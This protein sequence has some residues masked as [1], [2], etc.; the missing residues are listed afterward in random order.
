MKKHS[1]TV[2]VLLVATLMGLFFVS[3]WQGCDLGTVSG[4]STEH[5]SSSQ[6][7]ASLQLTNQRLRN[8]GTMTFHLYPAFSSNILQASISKTIGDVAENETKTFTVPSGTWKIGYTLNDELFDMPDPDTSGAVWPKIKFSDDG[9]YALRVYT[10]E[11]DNR[12]YWQSNV[13]IVP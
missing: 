7:T 5:P 6:H 11:I 1:I 13:E 12:T 8:P 9:K 3:G 10:S 2:H 4:D